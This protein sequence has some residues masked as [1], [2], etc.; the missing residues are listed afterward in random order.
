FTARL[1]FPFWFVGRYSAQRTQ[2]HLY[3]LRLPTSS[4]RSAAERRAPTRCRTLDDR[5]MLVPSL[6][7]FPC[8]VPEAC[9]RT[10]VTS[11]SRAGSRT[12][13]RPGS[14]VTSLTKTQQ[15]S[16]SHQVRTSSTFCA[17]LAR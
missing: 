2:A 10:Y 4:R 9:Y 8:S 7:S 13:V 15:R 12:W 11:C 14:W 3:Q 1:A 16:S 6:L 17:L 5:R